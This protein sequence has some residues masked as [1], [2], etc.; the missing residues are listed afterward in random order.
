MKFSTNLTQLIRNYPNFIFNFITN[1]LKFI[2][3]NRL[4]LLSILFFSINSFAQQKTSDENS[5]STLWK[6]ESFG[7]QDI[8]KELIN[9][10]NAFSKHF[11]NAAPAGGQGDGNITAHIASGPINY[12][13]NG[14][15]KTI[16]HTI[17]PSSNGFKNT[18]NSFKTYF[19]NYSTGEITTT[20]PNGATLKDMKDMKMYFEL[21]GQAVQIQNIQSKSGRVDFNELTYSNVYGNGI[22]LRLTQNSTKRKMDYRGNHL[23]TY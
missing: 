23:I 20:L 5:S 8:S 19:P 10:R 4:L 17:S 21:N 6:N 13:E 1:K 2:N 16:F 14:K 11:D 9:K 12:K 7:S 18:H 15:W 3:L 22:D